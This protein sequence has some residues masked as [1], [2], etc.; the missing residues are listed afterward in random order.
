MK[1]IMSTNLS[2]PAGSRPMSAAFRL[3]GLLRAV[4]CRWADLFTWHRQQRVLAE[5]RMMSTRQLE[6]IG[7]TRPQ[8]E[9]AVRRALERDRPSGRHP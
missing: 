7:I 2:G 3:G 5:L 1:M 8:L 4:S 6:D 9:L